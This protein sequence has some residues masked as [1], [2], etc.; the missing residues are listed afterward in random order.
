MKIEDVHAIALAAAARGW[1]APTD[2]WTV[3]VRWAQQGRKG[4]A[5]DLFAR[6][7]DPEKLRTLSSERSS[8][9]TVT[10][11]ELNVSLAPPSA[12]EA[13]MPGRIAGPRYTLRETLGSGGVGD[14]VAALDR[15]VR[16]VVALKTLQRSK[17]G[18]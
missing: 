15:E 3:A 2:I 6:I 1:I 12:I 17:A 8:V 13:D 14:V 18:D 4:D 16:R 5:H 9:D 7:L 10:N 11:Q